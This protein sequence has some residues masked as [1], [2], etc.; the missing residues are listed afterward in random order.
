MGKKNIFITIG[1]LAIAA[2]IVMY[3]VGND[4][5]HLSEL[6]NYWWVPLPLFLLCFLIVIFSG[7]KKS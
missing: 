4:S 6:K 7:K 3:Q 1:V 5:T 2:S